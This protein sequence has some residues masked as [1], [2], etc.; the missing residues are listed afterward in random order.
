MIL[1]QGQGASFHAYLVEIGA[2][3]VGVI[4]KEHGGYRFFAIKNTFRA[5]EDQ[6]FDSA[7]TARNA[8]LEFFRDADSPPSAP[9]LHVTC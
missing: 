9:T 5:L 1:D 6:L 3:A 2:H 4:A 7:D 8:A